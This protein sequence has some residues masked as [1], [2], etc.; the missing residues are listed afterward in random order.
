MQRSHR[1]DLSLIAL[2]CLALAIP[3]NTQAQETTEWEKLDRAME[4]GRDKGRTWT[5]GWAAFFG[6]SALVNLYTGTNDGSASARYDA[7]VRTVTSTLGLVDTILNPAPHAASYRNYR[8]Y[9]VRGDDPN[10]LEGA[11]DVAADLMR[12]ERINR[13]WRAR[14]GAL[15]VNTGAYF[16]IAEGDDRSDDALTVALGGLLV[17]EIKIWTQPRTFS[18]ASF[19]PIGDAGVAIYPSVHAMPNGIALNV[20]F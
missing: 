13:G 19:L 18:D 6:T 7:R 3:L 15:V 17:N 9:R 1:N 16:A 8:S 5:R 2:L 11:R 14:V 10:A 20:A 12:K 4:E